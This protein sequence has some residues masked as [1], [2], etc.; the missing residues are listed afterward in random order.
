MI[1]GGSGADTFD[2]GYGNATINGGC[3][4]DK[5]ILP[6]VKSDYTILGSSNN[7]TIK[8]DDFTLNVLNVE[9]IAFFGTAPQ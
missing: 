5:L 4:W 6:D 7:Y 9:E 3:G 8:R 2:V 1:K